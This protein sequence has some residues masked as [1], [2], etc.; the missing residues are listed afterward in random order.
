MPQ[1]KRLVLMGIC[2]WSSIALGQALTLKPSDSGLVLVNT[3]AFNLEGIVAG[4]QIIG[5]LGINQSVEVEGAESQIKGGRFALR[6]WQDAL[7]Q[8][9]HDLREYHLI[10]A[11]VHPDVAVPGLAGDPESSG[12]IVKLRGY[13]GP[14]ITCAAGYQGVCGGLLAYAARY[15]QPSQFAVLLDA[16][17][18]DQT[19]MA[20]PNGYTDLPPILNSMRHAFE[21]LGHTGLA[22]IKVPMVW[23]VD[24]G[25]DHPELFKALG[26]TL[27]QVPPHRLAKHFSGAMGAI[28]SAYRNGHESAAAQWALEAL[29]LMPKQG[30]SRAELRFMCS[31]FDAGAAFAIDAE[32]YVAAFGYLSLLSKRCPDTPGQRERFADWFAQQGTTAFADLR[33]ED[34]RTL[35]ERAHFFD[36]SPKTRSQWADALAELAILR[37]RE[38]HY[39]IGRGHLRKAS[40]LAPFRPK[41]LAAQDADP[42][43]N[44]R[45]KIGIVIL[46]C[47]LGFFAIRRLR[48]VWFGELTRVRRT[49]R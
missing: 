24:R 16:V 5:G 17:S 29:R 10:T 13:R 39:G 4:D 23:L 15:F 49:R 19:S 46:I 45:A 48:R 6:D 33:L 47:F 1:M 42:G 14:L 38:G 34:A 35:F 7:A 20:Y 27:S 18:P 2:C 21:R 31:G 3:S 44:K 12:N 9:T 11:G 32:Q 40:E 22:T 41:V 30:V 43:G 26:F 8:T 28:E 36:R 25:V 37:F